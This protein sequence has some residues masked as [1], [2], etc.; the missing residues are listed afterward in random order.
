MDTDGR[1]GFADLL[2]T[3]RADA[4]L[5]LADLGRAAHV[6]RGYIHHLE[7]GRR[8]PSHIFVKALDG[9]L[10][11]RGAL[12]DAW[13]AA[14]G[15]T[16]SLQPANPD[17]QERL[18]LVARHPRRVDSATVSALGDVLAATRR[19][20]DSAG[21]AAVLPGVRHHLA[22]TR[23]FLTDACPPV[24][25]RVGALTGELHQYL[26]WLLAETG[27]LE[28]AGAELDAAL[29]IGVEIDHPDLASLALSYKGHLAWMR[30]DAHEVVALSRAALRDGRVFVAQRAYNLHQQARGWAMVG[31]VAEVDRT[32]GLAAET[33]ETAVARQAEAPD[34]MYWYGA[35]FFTL[36]RGLTWHTVRDRRYATRAAGELTSGLGQLPDGERDSEWAAIFTVAAAESYADAGDPERAADEAR[37]AAAVCRATCSTRLAASLRRVHAHLREIW[38][39]V[40][41]VRELGDEVRTLVRAR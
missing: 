39:T 15:R 29:A 18:A 30:G 5:S 40:P 19:L 13:A 21:S 7:H 23:K 27:H 12:M 36:Q 24:R 4:G 34:G 20:E 3:L 37:R 8:W 28:Q 2:R 38:P 32:L 10:D 33:A 6:A 1:A 41:A 14:H 35:G 11:A 17:D 25:D 31:D 26:G 22:L 16:P 9:A